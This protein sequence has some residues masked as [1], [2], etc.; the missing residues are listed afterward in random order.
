MALPLSG[1]SSPPDRASGFFLALAKSSSDLYL[2]TWRDGWRHLRFLLMYSPRWL[3]LYPGIALLLIGLAAS[4]WLL[5]SP[6]QIGRVVFDVHTILF[7]F[8]SISVG[9][10]LIAFAR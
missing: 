9:F 7:A 8:G 4:F 2:R 6:R 5:L 10:Q 1:D 3:F